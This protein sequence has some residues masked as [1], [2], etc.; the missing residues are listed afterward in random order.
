MTSVPGNWFMHIKKPHHDHY[1]QAEITDWKD[2]LS[3]GP[4]KIPT[5]VE[6][7]K[8]S[9]T[10]RQVYAQHSDTWESIQ[11]LSADTQDSHDKPSKKERV[12]FSDELS[13]KTA[14]AYMYREEGEALFEQKVATRCDDHLKGVENGSNF[15]S[16]NN[17]WVG[18]G[19]L[20]P[21]V[22]APRKTARVSITFSPKAL[23]D[24]LPARESRGNLFS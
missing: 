20:Q 23:P 14:D 12:L 18:D 3:K 8:L 10:N 2:Q 13:N 5:E 19:Y 11:E 22:P 1:D 17:A 15:K 21:V 24:H 4:E 6:A 16:N 7:G 9:M